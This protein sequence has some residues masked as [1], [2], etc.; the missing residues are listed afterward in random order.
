MNRLIFALFAVSAALILA[1]A[2]CGKPPLDPALV[3]EHRQALTLPEE[4]D[5]AVT[6][7][8][9][10]QVMMGEDPDAAAEDEHEHAEAEHADH[11]HEEGEHADAGAGEDAKPQAADEEHAD[12]DHAADDH[13][14]HDHD[15][16]N[17][18]IA[19]MDV[20]LV[21]TVG[22]V[23]NPSAQSY[24]EFPFVDRE[25]IFFLADPAA[26]GEFEEH[27]HK[28]APGEEC[29]FCA[30]HAADHITSL[31]LVHFKG[32]DGKPLAVGA[33]ELFG[34]KDQDTVVVRGKAKMT[35]T[36]MLEVDA[37][38]LYVRR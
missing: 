10:H 34:L 14:A 32:E 6:V 22:G 3:A 30:S 2:G 33:R 13:A 4:P 9:V 20:V 26:V 16:S 23:A 17:P 18:A 36:G 11:E 25:A 8:E 38:G 15:H 12:H 7:L 27:A 1:A 29:A 37:T 21:G 24:P 19:E 5:G 31:A 28:H 35:P